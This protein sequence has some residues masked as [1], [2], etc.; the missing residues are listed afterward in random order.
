MPTKRFSTRSSR[1][2]PWAR[3][4]LVELGQ[5]CRGREP[6]AVK[7]DRVAA[8]ELDADVSGR[9][10]RLLRIERTRIDVIGHLLRRVLQHF[11]FGRSMQ[12][13]GVDRERRLAALVLRDRDLVL[14][15]EGDQRLARTQVPF[16]PG[17]DHGDVGLE[18]IIGE[19]EAHLV[20]ALSSRSVRDRIGADLLRDLDLLLGDQ[21]PRDRGPKQILALVDRIGAEHREDVVAHELLA[22]ILDE[23]VLRLDAQQQRLRPRRLELLA[24][25]EVG[26]EGDDLA[27]VGGLQPLQDDGRVEPAGIGE[28]DLLDVAF[29]HTALRRLSA[30]MPAKLAP[31]KA[32]CGQS[33]VPTALSM[34]HR[35]TRNRAR[36]LDRPN[37]P[38]DGTERRGL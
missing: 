15:G 30:V 20:V 8:F 28:D 17:R 33:T 11:P 19:L 7:R 35:H 5:H 4:S 18:R 10:G 2:M 1:P 16:P 27:A 26:G 36:W 24:L 32:G 3:P 6:L 14:L 22:Q 23:D 37:E 12:Q 31:A 34:R 9:V 29:G 21:R 13:V 38:G 25:A